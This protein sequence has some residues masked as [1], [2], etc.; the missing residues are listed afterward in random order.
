M[1][2]QWLLYIALVSLMFVNASCM[3]DDDS[4]STQLTPYTLL[5]SFSIGDLT[6]YENDVTD[7]G[8]DTI[9]SNVVVGTSY[10]FIIDQKRQEVYNPDSL[11]MGTDV[12]AVTVSVNSDGVAY[13]YVDSLETF[14]YISSS[15]SLDFTEPRRLLVQSL[16]AQYTREYKVW[17]N[18]H[19]VDPDA[20]QWVS[21]VAPDVQKPMRALAF[22][23][24]M[25][26]FGEDADGMPVLS[27][28]S[29]DDVVWSATVALT[30][31]PTT[32]HLLSLQKFADA[33]YVVA[34][35]S[36]YCSTDGI[37]WNIVSTGAVFE[38]LLF[39][40]SDALWAVV[41]G[42]LAYTTDGTSFVKTETLP[43]EFPVE[44]ISSAVYP[45]LTNPFISRYL[46]MGYAKDENI[47]YPVVWSKLSNEKSWTQ[48]PVDEDVAFRCP[49]FENLT[50]LR[51][52]ASLYAFGGKAQVGEETILPFETFYIS[53]D[54][55][56]TWE[57]SDNKKIFL[58]SQLVGCNAPY[59][60][61]VDENN[62]IWIILGGD[63][64]A[65]WRGAI[66]RLI[67]E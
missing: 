24:K 32:A 47:S 4:S 13:I 44:N 52:D 14:V 37:N 45:L 63:D 17:L 2:K 66:N 50:M 40:S 51:Y 16:D 65:V 23:G 15:D 46:L 39:S 10:P 49:A 36:L 31:L 29:L 12:T 54:N 59:V 20:M 11:P 56:L 21:A 55:G 57:P 7:E 3:D 30:T 58:P 26:L 60:S 62:R 27:E 18:V 53:I 22:G 9:V 34:D 67:F 61:T 33:L 6:S 8:K 42:S 28:S 64:A 41:D 25:L 38:S 1:K 43:Q 48:Y 35:G 5:N 19:N